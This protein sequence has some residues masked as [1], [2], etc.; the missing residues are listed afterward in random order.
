MKRSASLSSA[1]AFAMT[2]A[3]AMAAYPS[4][5]NETTS[6]ASIFPHMTTYADLHRNDPVKNAS[7][8]FPQSP[9]ETT[10][11]S[12]IFPHVATY[13]DLQENSVAKQASSRKDTS[14]M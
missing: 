12:S 2:A 5:V 7:S 14:S 3:N 8:P 9:N 11:L 13:A 4:S 6:L 1:I 10:S